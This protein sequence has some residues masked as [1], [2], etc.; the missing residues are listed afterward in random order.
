M[1]CFLFVFV[2]NNDTKSKY[3]HMFSKERLYDQSWEN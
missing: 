3:T 2:L 1:V